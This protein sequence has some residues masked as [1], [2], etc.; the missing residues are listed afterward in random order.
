VYF[1]TWCTQIP[2]I[3]SRVYASARYRIYFSDSLL[4]SSATSNQIPLFLLFSFFLSSSSLPS[5]FSVVPA[6]IWALSTPIRPPHSSPIL[7]PHFSCIFSLLS[8]YPHV[9]FSASYP[10][11]L[12]LS[13][14]SII[15][16]LMESSLDNLKIAD[17]GLSEFY[18]PG[19]MLSSTSGTLSYQAPEVVSGS[20]HAGV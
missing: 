11:L 7:P 19:G 13:I 5:L 17:F 4:S 16:S 1:N 18:R 12:I 15:F 20:S 8:Y 9:L 3:R 6:L 2:L 14:Y 10:N